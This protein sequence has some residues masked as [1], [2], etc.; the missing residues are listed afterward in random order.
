V[1]F[2]VVDALRA[3]HLSINGY[4]RKTTPFIDSLNQSGTLDSLSPIRSVCAESTCGLLA[5]ARSKYPNAVTRVDF[6]LYEVLKQYGY[7][8]YFFLSGDHT[9]F[10]QMKEAY[11][12][13]DVYMDGSSVQKKMSTYVNDDNLVIHAL[14]KIPDFDGT[15]TF[16]QFHLMSVH[17]L[18]LRFKPDYPYFPSKNYYSK[19][20]FRANNTPS[21]AIN[22]YDNGVNQVD[23]IIATIFSLLQEKKYLSDVIIVITGDHGDLLGEKGLYSHSK[24]IEEPVLNIPFIVWSSKKNDPALDFKKWP[25]AP[26]VDIAPSI[27]QALNMTIPSS[28]QGVP[29]Q[30]TPKSRAISVSQGNE[31]GVYAADG[32]GTVYKLTLNRNTSTEHSSILNPMT[33]D[34]QKIPSTIIPPNLLKAMRIQLYKT[35]M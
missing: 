33:L 15:P 5:L 24:T 16:I 32:Q 8:N 10:Y 11:N 35:N 26:Q 28:W 1:I 4:S 2:I 3:D 27:L 22:Y 20:G 31:L 6:S 12:P 14:K 13:N 23:T 21:L 17:G 19:V 29:L 9:H 34:Q 30:T 25:I 18:G 7:N